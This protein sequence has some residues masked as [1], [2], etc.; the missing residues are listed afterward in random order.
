MN[1]EIR[2]ILNS[3][4]E[5]VLEDLYK[6]SIRKFYRNHYY[7]HKDQI[8]EYAKKY[9]TKYRA[10]HR[11]KILA[12]NKAKNRCA[13]GGKYSNINK[14]SHTKTNKH[15]KWLKSELKWIN[16]QKRELDN[17]MIVLRF[18]MYNYAT[19]SIT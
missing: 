14:S 6:W 3:S 5:A 8:C 17:Q 12:H 10:K 11:D 2:N 4:S 19:P 18:Q 13:C 16:Q 9:A 7:K 1:S 15:K